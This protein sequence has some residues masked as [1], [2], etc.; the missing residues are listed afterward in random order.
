MLGQDCLSLE[1]RD[2]IQQGFAPGIEHGLGLR[3]RGPK[4]G[5]HHG[6]ASRFV[7]RQNSMGRILQH[8]AGFG[9]KMEDFCGSEENLRIGLPLLYHIAGDQPMEPRQHADLP[10][11]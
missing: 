10:E 2:H 7:G 5:D 9:R 8:E 1:H 6:Q 4:V 11:L 3:I